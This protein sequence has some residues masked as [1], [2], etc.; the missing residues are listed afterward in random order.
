M[1]IPATVLVPEYVATTWCHTPVVTA[2]VSA[3]AKVLSPLLN[4]PRFSTGPDEPGSCI[5]AQPA[6]PPRNFDSSVP[7]EFDMI[8]NQPDME[9]ESVRSKLKL[10]GLAG[11]A[12]VFPAKLMLPP[13]SP[14][15]CWLASTVPFMVALLAFA[16]ESFSCGA[17]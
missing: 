2:G 10:A 11:L 4:R 7:A 9:N 1:F 12:H 16:V 3:N 15:C 6:F 17:V 14:G 13:I 8:L 5:S